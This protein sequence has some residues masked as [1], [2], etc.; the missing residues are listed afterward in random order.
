M[1]IIYAFKI[2]FSLFFSLLTKKKR[3]IINII[4]EYFIIINN[5]HHNDRIFKFENLYVF[6]KKLRH[7]NL[8]VIYIY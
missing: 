8:F 6:N 3:K 1:F 7:K 4:R 5:T 2:R